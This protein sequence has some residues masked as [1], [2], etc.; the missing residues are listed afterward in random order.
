MS[1]VHPTVR[2]ICISLRTSSNLISASSARLG[3]NNFPLTFATF[4]PNYR[5]ESRFSRS[6]ATL[7]R[8]PYSTSSN[9]AKMAPTTRLQAA[10]TPSKHSTDMQPLNSPS[11]PTAID[12][13]KPTLCIVGTG[14]AGWTLAQELGATKSSYAQSHNILVLSPTRTMALTPLLASAACSIFDYRIAEEPVRRLSNSIIKYQV[15]VSGIDFNTKKIRCKPA[16]GSNGDAREA[17]DEDGTKGKGEFEVAYDELILCPGS[18]TN[19][20]GTPGVEEHCLFMRTINDASSLRE[21]LLDC[22]ELAS[23]PT[24]SLQEKKNILHIIIVGGGPTGVE[25]AAEMDELIHNHLEKIYR[26]LEGL[27]NISIYDVADRMLGNFDEALSE[28]AMEKFRKR[29]VGVKMSKTI[30]GFEKGVMKVKEDGD[31]KFGI[32]VWAAGNKMSGL[33]DGLEVRKVKG[34]KM[35][36]DRF[37]RVLEAT[38]EEED[39]PKDDLRTDPIERVYALGDA[40]DIINA[41]LP[42]TAEV[43]VQQAKWLAKHLAAGREGKAFGYEQRALKAYIGR[44]DGVIE[45]KQDWTGQTAWLAWRSGTLEWTRSWRRRVMICVVWCLNKWDGREIARW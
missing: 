32:A 31:I 4:R 11:E 25:L 23:L 24:L 22:F 8:Y 30:Q 34:G 20:F 6:Q 3:A 45:G 40:A 27:A 33:V 28:Y 29:N 12:P 17:G 19:T 44:H 36:T 37:L 14:W 38:E 18:E 10:S 21:R 9:P 26:G 41:P 2:S 35:G 7:V 16:I 13:N 43:A 39:G 5:G 1:R 15:W 42:P